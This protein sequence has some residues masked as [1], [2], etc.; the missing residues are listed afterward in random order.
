[1]AM[2]EK[3]VSTIVLSSL[4]AAMLSL[5]GCSSSGD[6]A[7]ATPLPA[8]DADLYDGSGAADVAER[9]VANDGTISAT[10]FAAP[11]VTPVAKPADITKTPAEIAAATVLTGDIIADTTLAVGTLYKINGLVKV[12]NGAV[13]TIEPGT[14]IFGSVGEDFLVVTAGSQIVAD[15]TEA[16]PVVFTSETALLDPTAAAVG[17]WGGVTVLGLAP[18]NHDAP[19]YEVDENDPDFAFGNALAGEGDAADNSGILRNV[20]VLNSGKTIAAGLEINGLS[21]AG[22]GSGTVVENIYI[23]NSSDDCIEIWGGTVNV[24]SATMIN[25]GDDSFDLDYGYVGTA[26]NIV[27]VQTA[28]A[29][30]GFEISSGGDNPMTSPEIKNFSITKIDGSDEGGIYIK[31]DTTAPTFGNGFVTAPGAVDAG[32][33]TK[34]AFS[35]DQKGQIA[36][37][38]VTL[39]SGVDYDGS[40]AADVQEKFEAQGAAISLTKPADITKTPAEITAATELTGDIIADTTLAVGTLYKINGLVKVKNGA[41]LT[42]EPGTV[43]FGSVGEDFLVVTAGSQ[44]VADGTEALPVVFTSETALLDPTAAAVGQWG[45]VTVLGLAPTNHD[46]PFYEVDEN[47]PDF[48]FGNALAG[49]GD[50]ADNSGILRNVAVL[51]SGKTIAAGLEI[52]GLSLAGVGSGTVVENIYIE[53]SSDDCI[54]IWGGTVNVNSATMINCGDDSFDLDYG[55]VGTADNIVVVQTALAHAGFEISSGGDNPMTSPEIKNF[56][57]TKIDGSDEGGIYIKDDTTAPTFG[58]GFVT[59]PGAVDAAIHTKLAF[60]AEQ[61]AQIAFKDVYLKK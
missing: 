61:K 36:F 10:T 2:N 15:G 42:I 47:D 59:A 58:N 31:D 7:A 20:A 14:V 43:I 27:V 45:G 50:A 17:Q 24:N 53:N 55:Y 48:A 4:T 29:H 51:N 38:G 54:E 32:I 40:G 34:L 57:I 49:E 18:T 21:L 12:K 5:S 3:L 35:A 9:H 23:E 56:S 22:V 8:V 1:M 46:A 28:L 11:A 37:R 60:S 19:F 41:V 6:T 16:L 33:H 44:I 25:C 30:A 52:N 39:T 13:L 26:D